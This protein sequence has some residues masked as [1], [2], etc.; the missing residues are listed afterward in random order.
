ACDCRPSPPQPSER[1]GDGDWN[2]YRH[3]NADQSRHAKA[4]CRLRR[5]VVQ[6]MTDVHRVRLAA[7]PEQTATNGAILEERGRIARE[8]HETVLQT[9]YAMRLKPWT[10]RAAG[11]GDGHPIRIACA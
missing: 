8:L 11:R 9:L 7:I 3:R 10:A 5:G 1:T 6:R 4:A 2:D